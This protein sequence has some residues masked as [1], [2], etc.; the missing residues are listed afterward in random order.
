MLLSKIGFIGHVAEQDPHRRRDFPGIEEVYAHVA[1]L[2]KCGYL[3]V[4]YLSALWS[5]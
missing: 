2:F 5:S 3:E 1:A 4:A